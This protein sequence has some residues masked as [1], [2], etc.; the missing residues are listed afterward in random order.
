M[1]SAVN[2]P[3]RTVFPTP[4]TPPKAVIKREPSEVTLS[5]FFCIASMK[6]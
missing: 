3:E 1:V 2:V 6:A 5:T 4:I